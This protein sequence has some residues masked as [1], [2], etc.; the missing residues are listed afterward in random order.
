MNIFESKK[1]I[2]IESVIHTTYTQHTQ[3]SRKQALYIYINY[4]KM[5]TNVL[6]RLGRMRVVPAKTFNKVNGGEENG[7]VLLFYFTLN[8]ETKHILYA[9]A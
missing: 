1:I 6:H 3:H 9:I 8:N 2:F 4:R 5:S 7:M